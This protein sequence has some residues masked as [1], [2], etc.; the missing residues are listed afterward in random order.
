MPSTGN[1]PGS[2]GAVRYG[3]GLYIGY[4]Y[5]DLDGLNATAARQAQR[6]EALDDQSLGSVAQFKL[7]LGG[8]IVWSPSSYEYVFNPVLRALWGNLGAFVERS[9]VL[10]RLINAMRT[11]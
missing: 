9:S 11:G 1:W 10:R 4:R 5:Y 3:E 6:G 2:L 7:G 8:R